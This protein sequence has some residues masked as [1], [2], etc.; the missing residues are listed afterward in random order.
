[1][2]AADTIVALMPTFYV[3]NESRVEI[4]VPVLL[5]ALAV[6]VLTGIVF[7]LAPA[8]QV[9]RGA[10]ADS[11][12]GGGRA[13]T[14]GNARLLGTLAAIEIAVA[15]MVVAGAGL[16]KRVRHT[17]CTSSTCRTSSARR[18]C[19]NATPPARTSSR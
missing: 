19:F 8:W 12:R 9:A 11:L 1:M 15:V 7:G 18:A 14:R 16:R 5:F 3:P 4:N 2:A 6:S 10:L 17:G 13:A